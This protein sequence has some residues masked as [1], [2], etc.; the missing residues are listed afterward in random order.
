[1]M[2][3][4][5]VQLNSGNDPEKNLPI[6][7]NYIREAKSGGAEF[8]LTPEN[9]NCL[10]S[11]RAKQLAVI[12]N[13]DD[14]PTLKRMRELAAELKVWLL[15]GSLSFKID[16]PD[17]RTVNRSVL[18]S[19][20]GK[21]KAQYDKIHMFDVDLGNDEVY[22]E[23]AL[24]RPGEKAVLAQTS[25]GKIGMSICYDL[26]FPSLFR[27]LAKSGAQILTIPAAFTV[28]TG[29]AHWHTLLQARAI[30]TGC[31]VLA[32][33]Q[34]GTHDCGGKTPRKTYGHSLVVS[35]WGQVLA[36]GGE[37]TGMTFADIDLNQVTEARKK[38]P[39]LRHDRTFVI[40]SE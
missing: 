9:T 12:H 23:S 21:V 31:F 8:I 20:D 14:D 10:S 32:P 13:Q 35:P 5:L 28:P 6:I 18:I 4:A 30:E 33:A 27:A 22:K 16:D 2:R 29:K 40:E 26:R 7:E 19:P 15:L 3:I 25:F 36:D 38:M 34:T 17:G 11:N 39:S 1:M 24:V 37:T